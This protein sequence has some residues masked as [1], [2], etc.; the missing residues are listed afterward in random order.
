MARVIA[1]GWQESYSG[2]IPDDILA[3]QSSTTTIQRNADD[4]RTR[5]ASGQTYWA[6][7]RDNVITGMAVAAP[8]R[9]ADSPVATELIAMYLTNAE[10][11]RG[12]SDQLITAAIGNKPCMLWV[13]RDNPR[14]IAFYRR[15]GFDFD[16]A[17]KPAL[18][19]NLDIIES[20]MVRP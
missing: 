20:R 12:T 8:A 1:Q 9:D 16:G 2:I 5:L 13:L 19:N 6:I 3:H 14:A 7:E 15:H 4:M 11:G 18:R 17:E 10:K